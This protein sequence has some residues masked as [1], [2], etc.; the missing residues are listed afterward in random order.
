MDNA[1]AR[2][3]PRVV[4]FNRSYWPDVEATGQ[5]LTELL[6]DLSDDFDLEVIAGQ[7][8]SVPSSEAYRP[9]GSEIHNGVRITRLPHTRFRKHSFLGRIANLVTFTLSALW[10][11]LTLPKPDVVVTETD[12]FLLPF[13]GRWL[14]WR[15]GAKFVVYLQDIYP[16]VA[17][18][19]GKLREGWISRCLRWLLFSVYRKADCVVVLSRDMERTCREYG[20]PADA[21]RVIPNWADTSRVQPHKQ[22]NPFRAE[23]G[24][25]DRFV[26]MY[27]GNMGLAHTL[28][29][30]LEA[31]TALRQNPHVCFVFIG[32]GARRAELEAGVA[33]RQLASV[34]FLPYQPR[35]RL[36]ESLS[37]ADVHLI[38]MQPEA[39]GLLMP[40][41][42]YGI[43][44]SGSAVIAIA[45]PQSELAELIQERTLGYV[46]DPRT[47]DGGAERLAYVINFLVDNP[48]EVRSL[49]QNARQIAEV[50]F[51]RSIQTARFAAMLNEL[52]DVAPVPRPQTVPVS[53][54]VQAAETAQP[55]RV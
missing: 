2:S 35:E 32:D 45:D 19:V 6:E 50:E 38:S 5:L 13:V 36:A 20:V 7:P 9:T 8:N 11:S 52:I 21:L 4:V 14:Q 37:A 28:T 43:L 42:L 39:T 54:T 1:T 29:P 10:T 27:S 18:A 3:R 55:E 53:P 16:D 49:G 12:P 33:A 24:L 44:A 34:R 22:L 26:V 25:D 40:S 31:A 15:H 30:I 47:P 23:H 48:A 17:V 51:D 46:C 41:K